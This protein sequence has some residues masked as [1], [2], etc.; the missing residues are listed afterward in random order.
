MSLL[1][2]ENNALV[3]EVY[4]NDG[5]ASPSDDDSGP[6]IQFESENSGHLTIKVLD[7]PINYIKQVESDYEP[8]TLD[9]KPMKLQIN[10]NLTNNDETANEAFVD[11]LERSSNFFLY[12][13]N[14]SRKENG[15]SFH[16]FDF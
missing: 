10:E 8:D 13:K 16:N 7:S 9:R 12:S 14:Y 1:H 11:S 2:P 3:S 4:V 5:Y 6:E 15:R